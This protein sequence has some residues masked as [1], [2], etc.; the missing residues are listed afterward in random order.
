MIN[1]I[2]ILKF[3][4]YLDVLAYIIPFCINPG[5]IRI[6]FSN[7]M[8]TLYI[9]FTSYFIYLGYINIPN[10]NPSNIPSTTPNIIYTANLLFSKLFCLTLL[11]INIFIFLILYLLF[12]LFTLKINIS[13]NPHPHAYF[14]IHIF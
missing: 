11:L 12:N 3:L 14:N 2:Y 7:T 9:Y 6:E 1:L 13:R 8:W 10:I 5:I 4:I